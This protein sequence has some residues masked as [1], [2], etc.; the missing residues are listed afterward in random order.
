MKWKTERSWCGSKTRG[1]ERRLSAE[2]HLCISLHKWAEWGLKGLEVQALK[3]VV[4]S[5]EEIKG[6]GSVS[7]SEVLIRISLKTESRCQFKC[8]LNIQ[9]TC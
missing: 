7:W 3:E 4:I 6:A 1:A 5:V 2:W 8:H 9:Y